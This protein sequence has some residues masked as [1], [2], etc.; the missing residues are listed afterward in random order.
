M[1]GRRMEWPD[2]VFCASVHSDSSDESSSDAEQEE[3]EEE[4]EGKARGKLLLQVKKEILSA[5]LSGEDPVAKLLKVR[6]QSA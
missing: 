6:E 2:I 4:E 1:K 5:D 3:E